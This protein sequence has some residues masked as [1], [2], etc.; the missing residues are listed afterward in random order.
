[1]EI[2]QHYREDERPFIDQVFDWIDQ[3]KSTYAYKLTD[4]LNPREQEIVE[5]LV[6]YAGDVNAAFFGGIERAE[7]KRGLIYPDYFKPEANDFGLR[8][9]QLDYPVKFFEIGHR[10]LLGALMGL[11]IKREKIGD[12]IIHGQAVQFVVASEIAEYVKLHLTSVD[13]AKVSIQEI[14]EHE[15]FEPEEDWK[16]FSGTVSSMRLDAVLAEIFKLSRAKAVSYIQKGYAKIN[17]KMIEQ[18]AYECSVSDTISL[19]GYGRAKLL[20]IEGKSKKGKWRIHYGK[21]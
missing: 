7:R 21:K 17:W 20:A 3:V 12:L 16:L 11:G 8:Y 18:P 1:M 5:Q 2:Y 19:R 6:N 4:F 10:Q 14:E 15:L 13:K 9:F